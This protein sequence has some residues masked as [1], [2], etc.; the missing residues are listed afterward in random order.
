M[1]PLSLV[2][3]VASSAKLR[4]QMRDAIQ[5]S[6]SEGVEMGFPLCYNSEGLVGGE[7]EMTK[8]DEN[9]TMVI[10][11]CPVTKGEMIGSYHTHIKGPR[12]PS[13]RDIANMAASGEKVICTGQEVQ[14]EKRVTCLQPKPQTGAKE[15]EQTISEINYYMFGLPS[16]DRY[17]TAVKRHFEVREFSV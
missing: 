15:I 9:S 17:M 13:R 14:D 1:R 3:R 4:R 11:G 5:R 16:E 12:Y 8:G 6:E 2:E 10:L 7:R